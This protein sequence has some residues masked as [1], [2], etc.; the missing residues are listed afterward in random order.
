MGFWLKGD[1]SAAKF[2]LRFIDTKNSDEDHPWRMGYTLDFT[3]TVLSNEWK[4]IKIPLSNFQEYG[5]WD[6][7]TWFNPIG[8]FDWSSVDRFEIV[9]EHNAL[10]NTNLWFDEIS[11]FDPSITAVKEKE[12]FNNYELFQNYPN[13]FNASTII[14]LYFTPRWS[15]KT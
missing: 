11:L 7:D 12:V 10:S 4:Y 9:N 5:S 14:K 1:D 3:N 2:D 15:Y 8:L 6:N 13:P